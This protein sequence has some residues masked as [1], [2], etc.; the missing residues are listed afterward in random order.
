[1][2]ILDPDE[3]QNYQPSFRESDKDEN[4]SRERNLDDCRRYGGKADNRE[5]KYPSKP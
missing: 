1:M 3:S 5:E 4:H 2:P